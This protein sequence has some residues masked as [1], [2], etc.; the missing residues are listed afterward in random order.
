M[1]FFRGL[2]FLAF[3]I[4]AGWSQQLAIYGQA[5]FATEVGLMYFN[6]GFVGKMGGSFNVGRSVDNDN[7]YWDT[8][9]THAHSEGKLGFGFT[10]KVINLDASFLGYGKI[11]RIY[12]LTE[13]EDVTGYYPAATGG[14]IFEAIRTGF[15]FEML[16]SKTILD[17]VSIGL[18]VGI[19]DWTQTFVTSPHEDYYSG[20]PDGRNQRISEVNSSLYPSLFLAF[21]I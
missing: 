9:T 16:L 17:N 11:G 1:N 12:Q 19:L 10:R 18:S 14:R 8:K 5:P 2:V 4:T 13:N 15:G 21:G 20:L 7:P 3:S 6:K